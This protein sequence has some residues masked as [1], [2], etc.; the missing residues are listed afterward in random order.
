STDKDKIMECE[1]SHIGVYPETSIE[2]TYGRNPRVPYPDIIRV[3]MQ[4]GAIAAYNFVKIE[5]N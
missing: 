2:E 3:V 5:P 4:D 1:A